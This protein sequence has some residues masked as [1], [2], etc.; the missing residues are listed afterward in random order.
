MRL[1]IVAAAL[2]AG[3]CS[4]RPLDLPE[5]TLP[6]FAGPPADMS[7]LPV[8]F[9]PPTIDLPQLVTPDLLTPADLQPAQVPTQVS[10][11]DFFTCAIVRGAAKCWGHNN[12]GQLG[13]GDLVDSATPVDVSG[14]STAVIGIAAGNEHA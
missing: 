8:D 12:R 11:G 3:G 5:G 13:N 9:A 14:L 6:D 4:G 2:I 1:F 10:A 7:I